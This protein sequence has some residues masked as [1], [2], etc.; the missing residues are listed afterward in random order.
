MALLDKAP[1]VISLRVLAT[2]LVAVCVLLFSA[3]GGVLNRC[4]GGFLDLNK[5]L[6]GNTSEVYWAQHVLSRAVFA[7]PTGLLVVRVVSHVYGFAGN[8]LQILQRRQSYS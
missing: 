6:P 7:L 2:L 5:I 1:V 3:V 8:V 4:R